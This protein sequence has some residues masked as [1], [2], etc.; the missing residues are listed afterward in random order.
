MA[1]L[2][3]IHLRD[4]NAVEVHEEAASDF[5]IYP[6]PASNEIFLTWKDFQAERLEVIDHLGRVCITVPAAGSRGTLAV[7][8]A[9]LA[10]GLYVLQLTGPGGMR[11]ARTIKH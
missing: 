6:N 3:S 7:P 9:S 5:R 1:P 4:L 10:S 11:T 8:M 2:Y